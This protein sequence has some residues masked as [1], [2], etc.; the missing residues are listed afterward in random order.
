M[1]TGSMSFDAHLHACGRPFFA[2]L[3]CEASAIPGTA[4]LPAVFG[5]LRLDLPDE[6]PAARVRAWLIKPGRD[7]AAAGRLKLDGEATAA[8]L[9]NAR[10]LQGLD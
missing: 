7:Q 1:T 5:R 9:G 8:S 2:A 10:H 4:G 3:A 6:D